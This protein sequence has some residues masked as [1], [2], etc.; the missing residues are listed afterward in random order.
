MIEWLALILGGLG[1]TLS[2]HVLSSRLYET[3]GPGFP[4]ILYL[5][6]SVVVGFLVFRLGFALGKVF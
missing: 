6:G 1:G 4:V 2:R 3:F 5:T